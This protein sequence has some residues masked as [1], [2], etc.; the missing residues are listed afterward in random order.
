[1]GNITRRLVSKCFSFALADKAAQ[2]LAPFQLG[3]GVRGG[4]EALVHTVRAL[5][6]DPNISPDFCCL[7]QVDLINAFKGRVHSKMKTS[8]NVI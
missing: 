5:M 7:L 6:E 4:C 8:Q 2:L 1:M 3:V